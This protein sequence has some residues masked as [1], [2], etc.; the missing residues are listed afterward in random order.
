MCTTKK[1]ECT[2]DK[3]IFSVFTSNGVLVTLIHSVNLSSAHWHANGLVCRDLRLRNFQ[4]DYYLR[5]QQ[6]WVSISKDQ[7]N[8]IKHKVIHLCRSENIAVI[9]KELRYLFF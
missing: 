5:T 9:Y 4:E 8:D 7:G 3:I 6:F 1:Y 2:H